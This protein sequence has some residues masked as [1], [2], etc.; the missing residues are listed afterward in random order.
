MKTKSLVNTNVKVHN[1]LPCVIEFVFET[2]I[3][4]SY[5]ISRNYAD[6]FIGTYGRYDSVVIDTVSH[7]SFERKLF[8]EN[9]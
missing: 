3:R 7:D 9:L 8:L 5:C 2:P 4:K 6:S 1:Y